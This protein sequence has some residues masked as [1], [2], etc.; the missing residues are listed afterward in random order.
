M[1]YWVKV[2][3]DYCSDPSQGY[4]QLIKTNHYYRENV[5]KTTL[6]IDSLKSINTL[7]NGL[8]HYSVYNQI[9]ETEFNEVLHNTIDKLGINII[10]HKFI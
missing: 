9:T 4:T 3:Y 6:H 2:K 1:E 8:E 5:D 10:N 7:P